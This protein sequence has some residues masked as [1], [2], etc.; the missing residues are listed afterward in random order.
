MSS[1][2][3]DVFDYRKLARRRLPHIIFDFLEGGVDDEKGL[4]HNRAVFE[5]LFFSPHRFTNISKRDISIKLFGRKQAA[6]ILIAPTGMNGVLWHNGDI[7][8]AQ[9]AEQ[10][11][12][13]F[14]LSTASSSS[15]EEVA[16]RTKGDKWFQLY[17]MSRAIAEKLVAR[18]LAAG[19]SRL[20]LTTDVAVNGN[21]ERDARN[22][23]GLP[24][25]YTPSLLLDGIKHPAWSMGFLI[26]GMPTL[27]NFVSADAHDTQS[28]A[29]VMS[30]Q[31][32]ATFDWKALRWLRKLWPRELLVKG[33][34]RAEDAV[35][36]IGEGADGVILSNHTGRQNDFA[37]SPMQVL[38]ET[39]SKI[40]QPILI[41]SGF[42]R[43]SDIVKALAL[44]AD[45]VLIGHAVLYG[46]AARGRAGA[47]D[48]LQI[49]CR[50]IDNILAQIGCTSIADLSPDYL[51]EDSRSL[52]LPDTAR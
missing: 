29:A 2:P 5:R 4:A 1:K 19:Y 40:S 36:A 46:L 14:L 26:H 9:A 34:L 32:D 21:R 27:G 47:A 25:K 43:G 3:L 8:L 37:I 44:G 38:A 42:R 7:A 45:A 52:L 33:I 41:D 24:V 50:E 31:M 18:A 16:G 11:G 13:P 30:R 49:L 35:R 10:A 22:N 20:V 48:V 39:R 17:V 6:P 23:F 28:Q 51:R 15:I 12:I